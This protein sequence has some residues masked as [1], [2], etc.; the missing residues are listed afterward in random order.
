M[1][2]R[3]ARVYALCL[4][5]VGLLIGLGLV[6]RSHDAPA[7]IQKT[8]VLA[9]QQPVRLS[10]RGQVHTV[11][12]KAQDVGALLTEQ[13]ITLAANE[14]VSLPLD[15]SL[16][17]YAL[18]KV[19]ERTEVVVTTQEAIPYETV[20]REDEELDEGDV[21][22]IQEGADGARQVTKIL[23][24]EDGQPVGEHLLSDQVVSEPVSQLV[25]LGTGQVAYRGGDR[26][27][28][29]QKL[30]MRATGY[31]S[32][33]PGLSDYTATGRL[34][35]YGVVAVDPDVIPLGTRVYVEGYGFAI[36]AD[37]GSAIYGNR[38]DLCFDT[39]GEADDYGVQYQTVYILK[40]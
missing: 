36:A 24:Y 5:F 7:Q 1:F 19:S 20:K 4:G 6:T 23:V 2:N 26:I 18:V 13:G 39:V 40:D 30:T 8:A 9:V 15:A 11:E 33:E 17:A 10:L 3:S 12:T 37:T 31:S 16:S 38:I 22:T 14:H 28:F 32:Q 34:A 27:R 35:R 25:T 21:K 29:S